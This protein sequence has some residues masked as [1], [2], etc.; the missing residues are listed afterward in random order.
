M[1][2]YGSDASLVAVMSWLFNHRNIWFNFFD[3][4]GCSINFGSKQNNH[5]VVSERITRK[6][7]ARKPH[8]EYLCHPYTGPAAF[9]KPAIDIRYSKFARGGVSKSV[10]RS[11]QKLILR[12]GQPTPATKLRPRR[13]L[14]EFP[15]FASLWRWPSHFKLQPCQYSFDVSHKP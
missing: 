5:A 12:K 3:V 14:G 10:P 6:V 1:P 15:P 13:E 8:P 2:S 11:P 4:P 9:L 7:W